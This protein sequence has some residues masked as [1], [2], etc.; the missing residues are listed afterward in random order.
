VVNADNRIT[1]GHYFY[2]KYLTDIPL[3]GTMKAAALS[4]DGND[5][6]AFAQKFV[7]NGSDGGEPLNFENNVGLEGTWSKDGKSMPV[8]LT[9]DANP[10]CR[11][12]PLV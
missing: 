4:L 10:L 5:G 7:G 1:G 3:T 2:A 9:A 8:K 12:R 6:G 11:Q